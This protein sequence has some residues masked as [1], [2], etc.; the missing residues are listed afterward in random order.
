MSKRSG[1]RAGSWA[2]RLAQGRRPAGAAPRGG[3]ATRAIAALDALWNLFD[4]AR[5]QA[6]E[7]MG[8]AGI[9]DGITVREEANVRR[10]TLAGADGGQR[11]IAIMPMLRPDGGDAV[12]AYVGTS[13]TRASM[14]LVPLEKRKQLLWQVAASGQ[15]FD[16]R[17][18]RDLFLSIFADDPGAT[19]RLSPIS[20]AGYFQ[21]PWD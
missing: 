12:G 10:Y 7:A 11:F 9:V 21:T 18:V 13:A 1:S 6:N 14:Y 2:E 4:E 3:E 15:S 17:V 19:K 20:G 8:A 16:A 5:G